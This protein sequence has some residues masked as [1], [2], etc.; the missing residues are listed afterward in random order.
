MMAFTRIPL[1]PSSWDAAW[2]NAFNAAFDAEYTT[3]NG[4]GRIEAFELMLMMDPPTGRCSA[5]TAV[6]R[7]G[8]FT[9][10]AMVLS[11]SD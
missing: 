3:V 9:F 6:I 1:G 11:K 4:V 2:V 8:P 10:T 7:T 5:A